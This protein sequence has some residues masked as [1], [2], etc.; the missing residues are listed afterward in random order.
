MTEGVERVDG[1][2]SVN[3]PRE[4][5]MLAA[6]YGGSLE[7]YQLRSFLGSHQFGDRCTSTMSTLRSTYGLNLAGFGTFV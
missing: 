6:I 3:R 5:L 7:S 4:I 1:R 2:A